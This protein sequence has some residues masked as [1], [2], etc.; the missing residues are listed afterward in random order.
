MK[1]ILALLLT[2]IYVENA[3]SSQLAIDGNG[4]G[5]QDNEQPYVITIPD[6]VTG[7]YLTLATDNCPI[8]MASSHANIENTEYSFP[9]GIF[10]YEL[11][12]TEANVTIYFH[13]INQL[14]NN[15]VYQKYGPTTPGD[16]STK[17]WY[18]LPNVTFAETKIYGQSVVTA[19]FTL[20]DGELGDDTGV[21]GKIVDP[22]G[23]AY[24]NDVGNVISFISK[25]FTISRKAGQ[26]IIT[27]NRNGLIGGFVV[28]YSIVGDTA[29]VGQD[30][31]TVSGS[32]VWTDNERGDKTFTIPITQTAT[33]GSSIELNLANLNPVL[34]DSLLGIEK[35]ILTITDADILTTLTPQP[36]QDL[37]STINTAYIGQGQIFTENVTI[38]NNGNISHSTFA[39]HVENNGIIA[40]STFLE[41]ATVSGGKL[42]GNIVNEGVVENINFV[43]NS[44][45]GGMLAGDNFN[46]SEVGGIIQNVYLVAG[47][48]LSNG[49]LDGNVKGDDCILQDVQ[50]EA[51]AN[52]IGCDLTGKITGDEK[53]PA[54]I[55]AG[56]VAPRTVL[57]DVKLSPT[58]ELPDDITLGEG[59]I[60]PHEPPILEDFG[61]LPEELA[62]LDEERLQQLEPAVFELLTAEDVIQIPA[63]TFSAIDSKQLT[64]LSTE[65]QAGIT[66]EQFQN[67][68][69]EALADL[70]SKNMAAFSDE[71]INQ[72]TPEHLN[73]LNP[74]SFQRQNSKDISKIIS[75]LD[76]N[77]IKIKDVEFLLPTDWSLEKDGT[78]VAPVG[79]K[80]TVQNLSSSIS[81][82]NINAG[83]GL[84]GQG[85][86][87]KDGLTHSLANEDLTDFVISQQP[88]DGILLVEGTGKSEGIK[89]SF[90]PDADNIIQVDT[91]KTPIG[92]ST[93]NGGF[94][95]VTTPEGQQYKVIPAPH[96]PLGVSKVLNNQPI[97]IGKNGDVLMQIP[98]DTRRANFNFYVAIFDPFIEPAPESWCVEIENEESLCDFNQQMIP[99]LHFPRERANFEFEQ[100]KMVYSDGTV[101]TCTPTVYS[102]E[103]FIA[104]GLKF[105]G[106]E[107]LSF[108]NNGTFYVLYEGKPYIIKPNFKVVEIKTTTFTPSIA[109]NNKGGINYSVPVELPKKTRRDNRIML[110]FDLFVEPAPE[111]WCVEV[112]GEGIFCDFD[113]VPEL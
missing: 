3:F 87:I 6:V 25:N 22:G 82:P 56:N 28:D 29:I 106:V 108:N 92:L 59:V 51:N 52:L 53:Y 17:A 107:K 34:E 20:R 9:Q 41:T 61:L 111:S 71:V 73:M 68:P 43:G 88:E 21:D 81:I 67:L 103:I 18:T 72:F 44:L 26:A 64:E 8:Q 35:A 65:A 42:S 93:G 100:A 49:I 1:I 85:I 24:N 113:N 11:Q 15:L 75:N 45:D 69:L 105:P 89:Y 62:T 16:L 5:I 31:Q 99:G 112:G 70:T 63:E 13:A 109:L 12:C 98:Q 91:E 10:Y 66:P 33:I 36:V 32:L 60:L 19:N 37:P 94:F 96:N 47:A 97:V 80:L 50:L 23:V 27:V 46:N 101:Q 2:I 95:R 14:K 110:M 30:F 74:V 38:T 39:A 77:T 102:P 4:D 90:I 7:E 79:V 48:T 55:G 54:Q 57:T 76:A 86:T 104:E 83:I 58:V 78:L 84:G 40:N